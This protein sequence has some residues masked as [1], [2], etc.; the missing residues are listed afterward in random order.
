VWGFDAFRSTVPPDLHCTSTVVLL[1]AITGRHYYGKGGGTGS[2]YIVDNNITFHLNWSEFMFSEP[3]RRPPL[4]LID[5]SANTWYA[6]GTVPG[7]ITPLVASI[8]SSTNSL[9]LVLE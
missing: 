9:V 5:F 3:A 1:L 6:P 7:T 2:K 8:T 4:T